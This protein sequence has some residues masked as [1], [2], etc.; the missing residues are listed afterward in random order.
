MTTTDNYSDL[1]FANDSIPRDAFEARGSLTDWAAM[2]Q[3]FNAPE[4]R[5]TATV[6]RFCVYA[7]FASVM[8]EPLGLRPFIVHLHGDTSKG[9]TTALKVVAS[10]YGKPDEGKALTRWYGTSNAIMRRAEMLRNVPMI[11]DDLSGQQRKTFRDFVYA[12]EGGMSKAKAS[13]EDPLATVQIRTW[14]LGVFS[15]GEPPMLDESALGGEAVRV[16]EFPGSPFG[17]NQPAL[18]RD[19]EQTIAHNYGLGI[20]AF[21]EYLLATPPGGVESRLDAAAKLLPTY[22]GA[23]WVDGDDGAAYTP[24]ER[25]MLR[26]LNAIF[27]TGAMVNDLLNLGWNVAEDMAAAFEV[28]RAPV[29]EKIR[30]V[31]NMLQF[32]GDYVEAHP[33][34]FPK[35]DTAPGGGN[36][37]KY[38]GGRPPAGVGIKGFLMQGGRDLGVIKSGFNAIMEECYGPGRA[39]WALGLLVEKGVVYDSPEARHLGR[40][41]MRIDGRHVGLVYFENFFD[42]AEGGFLPEEISTDDPF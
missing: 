9:K 36:A 23:A 7:G 3:R 35:V 30:T 11:L 40:R 18:I 8:L 15:S 2:L 41:Q 4:C 5:D 16:W 14:R 25:R 29:R 37:V 31:D 26:A 33:A 12:L 34:E 20:R 38:P 13:R 17:E 28:V 19:I 10:I 39:A 21:V 27:V 6:A 42:M 24:V 1:V 32:I 22:H